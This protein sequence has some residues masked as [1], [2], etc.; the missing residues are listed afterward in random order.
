MTGPRPKIF[1]LSST[2]SSRKQLLDVNLI[3][4]L[5]P[6][7]ELCG[8]TAGGGGG[9]GRTELRDGAPAPVEIL[10]DVPYR[11][12]QSGMM[13]DVV[14]KERRSWKAVLLSLG[15]A[16]RKKFFMDKDSRE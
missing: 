11:Q 3:S 12:R 6:G 7:R 16:V 14:G 4:G 9:R 10:K 13:V 5:S 15:D 2:S 1:Q 8:K